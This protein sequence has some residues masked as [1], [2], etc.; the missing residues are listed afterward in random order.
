MAVI[1]DQLFIIY[2]SSKFGFRS[3]NTK[4]LV[5]KFNLVEQDVVSNN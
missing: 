4:Y 5:Y 2:T 1:K 3:W